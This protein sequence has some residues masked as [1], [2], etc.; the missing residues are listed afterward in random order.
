MTE[1][2]WAGATTPADGGPAGGLRGL[3]SAEVAERVARGEVNRSGRGPSRSFGQIVLANV[4]NP[5]NGI[6]LTL[7]GLILVAGY[8]QDALFVGV[9]LSNSVVGIVQE[10]RARRELARLELLSEPRATVI[11]NGTVTEVRVEEVVLG[12]VVA[13]EPGHQVVVDGVV[14]AARALEVDESLLTGEA[15]PLVKDEGDEVR[16]GSFVVAGTGQYRATRVGSG[17]YASR[18]AS[19]ARRFSMAR[20]SLR[21]GINRVLRWMV[22]I[23]PTASVLLFL[24][25]RGSEETW[26]QALQGTV[27]AAVAMVP[28]GLVLLTSIAFVAGVLQLARH[29]A[30]AKQLSTVEVL[31]RVD[32]LCLDKTGTIT[33]GDLG[34]GGV[35]PVD[36]SSRAAVEETLAALVASDPTPNSTMAAIARAVGPDPGWTPTSVEPFSSARKWSSATFPGATYVLGAP[37]VVLDRPDPSLTRARDLAGTGRR[38]LVLARTGEVVASRLPDVR[39]A[40]AIIVLEDVVRPEAAS[41][42]R[43]FRDQGV[44]LKV[45]SGDDPATAAAIAA[46][47]GVAGTSAACDARS[48]GTGAE[49]LAAAVQQHTIV[50]RVSPHQKRAMITAL[51]DQGHVVAMIGDGVNDVLALKEADIGVAMGAGSGASRAVADLVLTD[52]SFASLPVVVDEGRKVI[53][54]IERIAN[55]FLTKATYA[56]LLTLV[57][58]LS[59]VPFPFL[60]RQLTLIGTFSIGVPGFF[61]A[62]APEVTRVRPGFLKRVLRFSIPAGVIAGGGTLVVYGIARRSG[63]VSLAESRTAA[64][65]T[66]LGIG[67]GVLLVV[68][69]PPKPWKVALVG[70]MAGSYGAIFSVGPLRDFFA[71]DLFPAWVWPVVVAVVLMAGLVC[72]S[73]PRWVPG[74]TRTHGPSTP[75]GTH[76]ERTEGRWHHRHSHGGP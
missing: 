40:V 11:R 16:S 32:V 55:L 2:A 73:L 3:T 24:S 29:H 22:A 20:S 27:A 25:L 14:V 56:V 61:L 44:E 49:D 54:N 66:L 38:V 57:V 23:I 31:A 64:T 63:S 58:A 48:L 76:A 71:L 36:G 15:E 1:R 9:V 43:Y 26:Q 30:L 21:D 33:T 6:M 74:P 12:D 8:P 39:C 75:P 34:V 42:I 19:E 52:S 69:R 67:L 18:L 72:A 10:T 50:G 60:P 13:V 53:N 47:A 51:Q 65:M 17:S 4:V 5:V 70:V 59:G 37:D 46:R 62:L 45:L 41:T 68:S 28:D 7:F 35:E